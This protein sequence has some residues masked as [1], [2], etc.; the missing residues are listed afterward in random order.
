MRM[1]YV[2]CFLIAAYSVPALAGD[3][4][5]KQQVE[6]IHSTYADNF[7]KQNAAGIAALYANG[8]MIVTGTGAHTDLAEFYG[9]LFK[10]GFDHADVRVDQVWTLG[11]D[12]LLARGEFRISGKNQS[13]APLE[14]KGIWTATDV[15][16]GETWKIKMF[17]A[18]QKAPPSKD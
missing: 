16:E 15:R 13:G 10:M 6:Q 1:S 7:N 8:G 9:G 3:A 14:F 11:A 4:E 5:F 17:S 18:I 12:T 2:L